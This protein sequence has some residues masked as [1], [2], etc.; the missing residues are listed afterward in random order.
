MYFDE[1]ESPYPITSSADLRLILSVNGLVVL[2]LGLLPNV[3]M[4]VCLAAAIPYSP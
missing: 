3:L 1:P 2:L 4:S